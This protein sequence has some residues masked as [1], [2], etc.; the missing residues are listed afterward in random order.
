VW[1]AAPGALWEETGSECTAPVSA[2]RET[3]ELVIEARWL[4]NAERDAAVA[5]AVGVA[6]RVELLAPRACPV[7]GR[8]NAWA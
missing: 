5:F 8:E 7:E 3:P 1:A 4:V 2:G 6:T